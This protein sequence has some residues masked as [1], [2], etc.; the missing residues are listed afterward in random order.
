MVKTQLRK[1]LDIGGITVDQKLFYFDWRTGNAVVVKD[2]I[3]AGFSFK[4]WQY[5]T[6]IQ[7]Y[8]QENASGPEFGFLA[9]KFTNEQTGQTKTLVMDVSS[10][11]N[12]SVES[13]ASLYFL[14]T[15][16]HNR[17]L[18]AVTWDGSQRKVG[19]SKLNLSAGVQVTLPRQCNVPYKYRVAFDDGDKNYE[20]SVVTVNDE[21][22][23]RGAVF[24]SRHDSLVLSNIP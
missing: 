14:R 2:P 4:N 16:S 19:L 17:Y 18:Y 5:P 1:R 22:H 20:F 13:A 21:I 11:E 23:F 3:E 8:A 7:N 6:M 12:L 24:T 9:A 10:G 15:A